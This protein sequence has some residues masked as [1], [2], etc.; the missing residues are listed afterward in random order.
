MIDYADLFTALSASRL[1]KWMET[2]PQSVQNALGPGAHGRLPEWEQV[3][4]ELPSVTAQQIFLDQPIPQIG[5]AQ[6]LEDPTRQALENTLKKLIPWRKG[7]FSVFGIHIDAE[8]RSD[9]KWDRLEPHI[10]RLSNRWVLDVG[11]GSGYHALRMAGAGADRVVGIDPT[12]LFVYQFHALKRFMPQIPVDVLPLGLEQL[13]RNLQGFDSVFSMGVLYHRRSPIDHL[14]ELRDC[15]RPGGELILET[16]I[17]EGPQGY[18]LMP[19]ERYARMRNVWFLPSIAT[20]EQWLERCGFVDVRCV[21]VNKTTPEE[22]R[23]TSWMPGDSLSNFLDQRN[24][25]LTIEGYP[26]PI[27]AVF[28]ANRKII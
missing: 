4:A 2:L 3:L 10:S 8:W 19:G 15:L 22:Q 16:L 13:P 25:T 28:I 7:P 11:C 12:L 24:P 18:A 6:E 5:A 9:I 21:D 14:L 23:S 17:C 20:T 26:A 1:K 27:R